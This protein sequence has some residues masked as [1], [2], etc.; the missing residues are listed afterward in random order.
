MEKELILLLIACILIYMY[1]QQ[2]EQQ[3]KLEQVEH[4]TGNCKFPLLSNGVC[5][6]TWE[7]LFKK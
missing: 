5:W 1:T 6:N 3:K 2:A 7:Q 4:L